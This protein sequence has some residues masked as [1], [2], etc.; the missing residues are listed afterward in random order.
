[1]RNARRP[2]YKLDITNGVA[3][4]TLN[5][6]DAMNAINMQLRGELMEM[7]P[8]LD[9]DREVRAVVF[10]GAGGKAFCV[11][12]DLKERQTKTAQELYEFRRHIYPKWVNVIANMVKPTVAAING[13]CLAGGVEIALQCDIAIASQKASFALPEVTLGFLPG[14]G[15]CQRLPRLIGIAKAKELILTGKRIDALEAERLGLVN[16]VVPHRRVLNEAF[17]LARAIAEN[18]P[19]S[20]VQAKIA[21]NASQETA[22]AGGLRFENEAWLSTMLSDIWKNKLGDFVERSTKKRR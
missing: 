9:A 8:K 15:A 19:M 1:M 20:V 17:K 13:Y 7:L 22:L 4:V 10:T 14:A 11:G 2:Y 3:L 12:A 18:P 16:R 21:I 5:R 6:P